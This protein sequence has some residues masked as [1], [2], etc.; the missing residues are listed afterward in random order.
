MSVG[1][2]DYDSFVGKYVCYGDFK[3]GFCWGRI[4][5]VVSINTFLGFKK[6]FILTGRMSCYSSEVQDKNGKVTSGTIQHHK[7]KTLLRCDVLNLERDII[8]N[9]GKLTA[10]LTEEDLFMLVMGGTNI[11]TL[12]RKVG[13]AVANVLMTKEVESAISDE[14]RKRLHNSSI[15]KPI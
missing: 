3:G 11:E 8:D 15:N 14:L 7:G 12:S 1:E 5:S 2:P 9:V 13:N 10:S 6:A 4:D